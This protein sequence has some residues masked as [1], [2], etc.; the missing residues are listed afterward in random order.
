M[1]LLQKLLKKYCLIV[2][3]LFDMMDTVNNELNMNMQH[4][5]IA[6]DAFFEGKEC[7]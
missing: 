6:L 3:L 7:K 2:N 4:D 5:L 1:N